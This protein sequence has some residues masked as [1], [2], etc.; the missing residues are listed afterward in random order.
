MTEYTSE[1][2]TIPYNDERIFSMLSNLSNLER[3]RERIPEDKVKNFTFDDDSCSFEVSPV[4]RLGFQ[5]VNREPNKTIKFEAVNSPIPILIWIQL[6]QTEDSVTK[7][8]MTMHADLNP[9]LKPM[10][11][12]PLNDALDKISTA[13]AEMSYE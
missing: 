13:I 12:K 4:G 7:L 10:V 9:F 5:I 3:I 8:R 1:I 11:S 6:K 2:K